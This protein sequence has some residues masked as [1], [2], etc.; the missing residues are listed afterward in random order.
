M[1]ESSQAVEAAP[2]AIPFIDLKAQQL[3]LK[4]AIDA[5]IA[6]VLAHGRFILGPEVAELERRL[7]AFCGAAHVVTC[8]SGTDALHLALISRDIGP[9]DAVFVPSFTFAAPAEVVVLLRAT[10]VFVDAAPD[11]WLIDPKSLE[12]AI[13]EARKQGLTPK[14]VIPVDL[15]GQPAEYRSIGAIAAAEGLL[16]LADAAHSFGATQNGK[17]VGT[18]APVTAT[19]F[20]P[21]K[22]LGCYGDGGAVF[23]DD[24]ETA[25][26]LRS[27]RAHGCGAHKYDHVRAGL[28]SRLDTLQ[29]AILL[30]KLAIYE[31]EIAARTRIAA[32]YTDALGDAVQT[33]LVAEGSTSVWAQYTIRV[34][35]RDRVA[36]RLNE[37]GI[38]TAVYYPKPLHRQTAYARFP[39][40]AGGLAISDRLVDKVL[41]LPMHPYL[42]EATQDRIV[43]AMRAA[44]G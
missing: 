6:R 8:A 35:N 31:E 10:P 19:S 1:S 11:T 41:S 40:A 24:A 43:E 18:L 36:A 3:R 44:A 26:L 22:P 39:V 2:A 14:A 32:R 7:A 9:G 17:A 28:N 33:Q 15:F 13:A 25:E 4:P 12:A 37:Q 23:T 20:F 34:E 16:V 42:D 5:G 29:A 27:L 21:A 38:P 30:E